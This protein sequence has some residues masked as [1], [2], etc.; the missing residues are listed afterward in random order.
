V[1]KQKGHQSVSEKAMKAL[2]EVKG[3]KGRVK[4]IVDVQFL[5]RYINSMYEI[6]DFFCSK[7]LATPQK[8]QEKYEKMLNQLLFTMST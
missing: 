2:E 6:F 7:N 1:R 8:I 4:I 5:V 3:N